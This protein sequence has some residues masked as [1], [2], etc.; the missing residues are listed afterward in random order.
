MVYK[1]NYS[2]YGV[3]ASLFEYPKEKYEA[4]VLDVM[5]KLPMQYKDAH[6]FLSHFY[7]ALSPLSVTEQEEIYTRTFD[8]QALTT[9]DVGYI[10]FGDD[11]KRGQL[12]SNLNREHHEAKNNCGTELADHLPNI[13]RLISKWNNKELTHEFVHTILAPAVRLMIREFDTERLE[14]KEKFY[15]TKY[16]TLIASVKTHRLMYLYPLQALYSVLAEDFSVT[17]EK[18]P[19]ES[20]SD[21]LRNLKFEIEVEEKGEPS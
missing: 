20:T 3:V 5:K 13:L 7:K 14:L 12:L 11:Y 1:M 6:T 17:E 4:L 9:L 21:F 2:H 10:L 15:I 19:K 8:V 16:K 18:N